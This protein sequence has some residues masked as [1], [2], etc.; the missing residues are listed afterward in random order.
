MADKPLPVNNDD[1]AADE[2]LVAY[3]D[4]EFDIV[5]AQAV[6]SRLAADAAERSKAE[7]LRKTYE[8]LEYLPKPEPSPTFTTRTLT[9]IEASSARTNVIAPS[10][11]VISAGTGIVTSP[12][13]WGRTVF[14]W[15]VA[16]LM[17]GAFGY[18][19]HLIA[20]PHLQRRSAPPQTSQ[21]VRLLE[22][23][24]LYVGVDDLDFLKKLDE[25]DLFADSEAHNG[26]L[27]TN[28]VSSQELARLEE[29][30][31]SLPVARQEQLRQLDQDF[32]AC[33]RAQQARL[34]AT[35]ERY[36]VWLGH[37]PEAYRKEVLSAPA[38]VE[39]FDA[40]KRVRNRQW[41]ESLPVAVKTRLAEVADQDEAD[42]ILQEYR[43]REAANR[44]DW[45][46]SRAEW[47]NAAS[48][49]K[50]FPFDNPDL[51]RQV[52]DYVAYALRPRMNGVELVWLDERK[53]DTTHGGYL[54]W[55]LYGSAIAHAAENHPMLPEPK[56]GKPITRFDELPPDFLRR[57]RTASPVKLP[58][59]KRD[60]KDLPQHGKWPDFA[61]YMAREAA[62]R[63]V[64]IPA[65]FGPSRPGEFKPEVEEVLTRLL[66]KLSSTEKQQ[67]ESQ[68]GKWPG[69]SRTFVD[70]C[71][72]HDLSIP[73][74]TLPGS[75]HEW[76]RTYPMRGRR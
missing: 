57:L 47:A 24:P 1:P 8:L 41:R 31:D 18:F 36:A 59:L 35:L 30:F 2:D 39:R 29:I 17:A 51:T 64:P 5:D 37:L 61:E 14:F 32:F 25:S 45:Q 72:K 53:K 21:Q 16:A 54:S 13:G 55:L 34:G 23:L 12:R 69:Y 9:Q 22:R 75:P 66:T 76:S 65:A 33:D 63:G 50:P 15:T 58:P 28:T 38:A 6:E 7:K 19:G 3:L 49:R 10:A 40:V 70:L 42:R 68:Q 73:N 20:Q 48:E 74:V 4:G 26:P 44:N 71:R 56:S 52:E 67:L 46:L 60:Y 27:T 11:P 62:D 43:R